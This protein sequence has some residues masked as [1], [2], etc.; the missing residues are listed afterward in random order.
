M[1]G[2][3]NKRPV[4]SAGQTL[5]AQDI[6]GAGNFPVLRMMLF[7]QGLAEAWGKWEKSEVT[8]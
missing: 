7:A 4:S 2:K 6:S 3:G 1:K 8:Q 5:D